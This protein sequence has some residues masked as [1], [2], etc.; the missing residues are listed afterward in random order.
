MLLSLVFENDGEKISTIEE[1][2][3]TDYIVESIMNMRIKM[4][5]GDKRCRYSP[6][7]I[8]TAM[9][10]FLRNCKLYDELRLSG[11]LCLPHPR[12]LR[13]ISGHLKVKEGGDTLLYS[14]FKEEIQ[15]RKQQYTKYNGTFDA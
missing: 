5:E 10:L 6:H 9:S 13:S 11:L 1:K 15:N 3:Y 4:K 8:N 14:V 2:Q 7:I 12:H